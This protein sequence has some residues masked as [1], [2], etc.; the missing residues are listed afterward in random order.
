MRWL[1]AWYARAFTF[2]IAS[3]AGSNGAAQDDPDAAAWQRARE[4]GTFEAYQRY[5][6]EFPIGRYANQAFRYMIEESLEEE[7]GAEADGLAGDFY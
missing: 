2:L 6:E 1:S 5:L 4:V 7:I 3:L